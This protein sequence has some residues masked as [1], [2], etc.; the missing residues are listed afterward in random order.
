M[1]SDVI[2]WFLIDVLPT[3]F[4]PINQTV[5]FGTSDGCAIREEAVDPWD[6]DDVDGVPEAL[7][8]EKTGN[9]SSDPGEVG[10]EH[11]E[12]DLDLHLKESPLLITPF[13]VTL[14]FRIRWKS[15]CSPSGTDSEWEILALEDSE[16][17]CVPLSE[18]GMYTE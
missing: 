10:V 4:D 16:A 7:L 13:E 18:C 5:Y 11:N 9:A 2:N 17:R 6:A 12:V 3:P 1:Y 15:P 8:F 14:K